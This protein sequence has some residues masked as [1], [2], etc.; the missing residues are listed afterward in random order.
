MSRSFITGLKDSHERVIALEP[1][2]PSAT[3]RTARKYAKTVKKVNIYIS[4]MAEHVQGVIEGSGGDGGD[5]V[6]QEVDGS[7]GV[8]R[9]KVVLTL[10]TRVFSVSESDR[11]R[12]STDNSDGPATAAQMVRTVHKQAL[13]YCNTLIRPHKSVATRSWIST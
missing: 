12:T 3:P 4:K 13:A 11:S 8:Y 7:E 9:K 5:I 10:T 2:S 1:L 6:R